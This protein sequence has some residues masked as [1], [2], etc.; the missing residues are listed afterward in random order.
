MI[1]DIFVLE[2]TGELLHHTAFAVRQIWFAGIL[3]F[4]L[5]NSH[6]HS[7]NNIDQ[8]LGPAHDSVRRRLWEGGIWLNDCSAGWGTG[9]LAFCY[10]AQFHLFLSLDYRVLLSWDLI[11]LFALH[12]LS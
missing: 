6:L 8:V 5:K 11:L 4:S 2:F 7:S 1:W 3:F 10:A 9:L 12:N